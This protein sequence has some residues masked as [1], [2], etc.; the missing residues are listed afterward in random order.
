EPRGLASRA[1]P[2]NAVAAGPELEVHVLRP[3][4]VARK[5]A[6]VQLADRLD[7]K[8][9]VVEVRRVD[10][11]H[12]DVARLPVDAVARRMTRQRA[13]LGRVVVAHRAAPGVGGTG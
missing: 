10:L 5:E 3:D 1:V 11:R 9:V 6:E 13:R 8:A 7:A 2:V 4:V 12:P